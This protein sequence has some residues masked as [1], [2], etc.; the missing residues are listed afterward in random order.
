MDV[1]PKVK[2]V[3]LATENSQSK[4]PFKSDIFPEDKKQVVMDQK[5]ITTQGDQFTVAHARRPL[6]RPR[7]PMF[8]KLARH[9]GVVASRSPVA[10]GSHVHLDVAASEMESDTEEAQ[11]SIPFNLRGTVGIQDPRFD[12]DGDFY[13]RGKDLFAGPTADPGEY[14]AKTFR[15]NVFSFLHCLQY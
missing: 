3:H 8:S 10:S 13:G 11:L 7:H 6:P 14:V 5:H 1:H 2:N 15:I 4:V 12:S 9:N